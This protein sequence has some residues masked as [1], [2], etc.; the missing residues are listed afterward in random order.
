MLK[1]PLK[2]YAAFTICTWC[3][4]GKLASGELI[5]RN[6]SCL[7]PGEKS[8]RETTR[9]GACRYAAVFPEATAF[10]QGVYSFFRSL[11]VSREG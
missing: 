11:T 7:T 2:K 10:F 4:M 1:P 8:Y 5:F 6:S 9:K 3:F